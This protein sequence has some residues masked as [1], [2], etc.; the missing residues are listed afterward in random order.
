MNG[1]TNA[2]NVRE[3]GQKVTKRF[4]LDGVKRLQVPTDLILENAAAIRTWI[5]INI[6]LKEDKATRQPEPTRQKSASRPQSSAPKPKAVTHIATPSLESLLP[7]GAKGFAVFDLETTGTN[8]NECRIVE[9]ALVCV[10]P[11]GQ[12]V[13][14]WESLVN[15]EVKTPEGS[16]KDHHIHNRDVGRAPRFEDIADLFAA[17]IDGH[18]LVAHNLLR[19]DL[20]ILKRHFLDHSSV[21][22]ELGVGIYTLKDFSG[23]P[24]RGFKKTLS[25]LYAVQDVAFNPSLAH[26]ALGDA[27]PLAKA[28]AAGLPHLKPSSEMVQVQSKLFLEAPVKVWTR[29]MLSSLPDMGWERKKVMLKAG[30]I[31]CTTGPATRKKDTPIRRAQAHAEQL[32]LQYVKVNSFSKKSPP[33]F[34]LSTSL[35]LENTKM[36]Q[37]RERRIPIVLI[38]Q[39][40]QLNELGH[41]VVVWLSSDE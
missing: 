21:E 7:Q 16:T 26:S 19:F 41:S 34:L 17:K 37:A 22:I 12:I 10:S 2:V 23:N 18:V 9:V 38:D 31:F 14:V 25:D 39:V 36:R 35:E 30:Q 8:T 33:D 5:D 15:P 3:D 4:L 29:G 28:L 20:P 6:P 24:D 27:L 40:H 32:G 13:E 1:I 11:E